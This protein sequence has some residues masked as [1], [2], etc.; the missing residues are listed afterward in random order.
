MSISVKSL[1]ATQTPAS[2]IYYPLGTVRCD[3]PPVFRSQLARDIACLLDVD[4]EVT[5]WTCMSVPFEHQ[6][7]L[8]RPDFEVTRA[9]ETFLV[10][11]CCENFGNI[12]AL[13]ESAR[14][15]GYRYEL[16]ERTAL[17]TIRLKNA[18]DLL[19][20]ARFEAALSDRIRLLAALDENGS[21][22]V[23]ECL[24]AFQE[25]KPVAGLASLSLQRFITMEL[26]EALIGPET[27]VRRQ[28]D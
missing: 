6:D 2:K 7:E 17:P 26:D 10:E 15:A 3:G 23:A 21:L 11:A 5:S 24:T 27:Q 13:Y 12:E 1:F 16:V 8:H 14:A 9:D 22:S 18:R 4:D 19:R 25:T 28:R 20:Y